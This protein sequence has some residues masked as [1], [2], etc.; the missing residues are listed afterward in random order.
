VGLLQDIQTSVGTAFD[1][2]LAD[3]VRDVEIVD[4]SGSDYDPGSGAV[5]PS[6]V[7]YPTRAVVEAYT[8]L[9][10]ADSG[11]ALTEK[12]LRLTIIQNEVAVD[13]TTEMLLVTGDGRERRI[14]ALSEDPAKA[15]YT[16]QARGS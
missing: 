7:R 1:G 4:V 11:G 16:L 13:V 10:I 2:V 3:A 12:D 14:A 15:T 6:E 5:V 9:E 8:A